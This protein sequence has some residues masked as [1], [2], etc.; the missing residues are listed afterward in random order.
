MRIYLLLAAAAVLAATLSAQVSPP[1]V[2]T[3][4]PETVIATVNGKD[5]TAGDVMKMLQSQPPSFAE[6]FKVDPKGAIQQFFV[7]RE[8]AEEGE[9][10]ELAERE[11]LKSRLAAARAYAIAMEMVNREQNGYPVSSEAMELFYKQNQARYSQAKVKVVGIRFMPVA[12]KGTSAEAVKDQA[13]I[14]VLKSQY[15]NLRSEEEAMKRAQEVIKRLKEGADFDKIVEQYSDDQDTKSMGGDFGWV[16]GN[17]SY[18]EAFKKAALAIDKPGD[19]GEP[20]RVESMLYVMRLEEKKV[21]PLDEVREPIIQEIRNAHFQS[22]FFSM[23]NKYEL[24]IKNVE[25]FMRPGA[26]AP[27]PAKPQAPTKP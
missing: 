10:K 21:Q 9:K 11:P 15:P 12:P 25:F 17:S 24:T 7:M 1:A 5:V 23:L 26:A 19:F 3:L 13:M 27:A 16:K 18:P 22:W 8:L 4:P 14:A 20:A 2:G 6:S